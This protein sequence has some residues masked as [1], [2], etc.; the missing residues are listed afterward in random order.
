[1][2]SSP[3]GRAI[4]RHYDHGA[5]GP[6]SGGALNQPVVRAEADTLPAGTVTFLLT[7]IE[8]STRNWE[9][10]PTSMRS[11]LLRHDALLSTGIAEHAGKVLTERGEGDSFFAV[12][13]R[14]S[15]AAAAASSLQ[16]ALNA[17]VWPAEI[18]M[19]VRMAIH[20]GEAGGDYR[21]QDVNRCA[22]LRA[23]AHG[24]Q[25]LV[26]STTEALIRRNLPPGASLHDLRFHRL[27]DL[28]APEQV[29]QLDHAD[30]LSEFPRLR[31]LDSFKHNLPLQLTSFVGREAEID[32]ITRR[33]VSDRLLTIM[34]TGGSGKTR[35]AVQAAAELIEQF[36]DGVWFVD[37]SELA[38][39]AQIERA[40]ALAL[41][42]KEVPGQ[43]L[44]QAIVE[45]LEDAHVLLVLDNCEH[46][47]D[48]AAQLVLRLLR[49]GSAVRILATSRESLNV[50]GEATRVIPSLSIPADDTGTPVTELERYESV[51][52]F[53]DRVLAVQPRF[54]LNEGNAATVV[55]ICRRLDGVPLAI[56]LG[57]ARA[58]TMGLEEI[59][60]RLADRFR[61]LTGGSRTALPRQQ[62]LRAA[63]D[64]SHDLLSDPEK[65]LF[66]RLAVFAGGFDL[67]AAESVCEGGTLPVEDILDLLSA[68]VA[69]SLVVAETQVDGIGRY[70]LHE[71]LR[72][73][74]LERLVTCAEEA[75]MRDR[76]LAF[77]VEL[78][79]RAY[80]GA[81]RL[82]PTPPW[83]ERQEREQDN[84]RAALTWSRQHNNDVF[85]QLAGALSW[86]WWLRAV[87]IS[88]GREWLG[89]AIAT[90]PAPSPVMARAL[91]GAS[92]LASWQGDPTGKTTAKQGLTLWR[93]AGDQQGIGAGLEALGWSLVMS[94]DD[95]TALR[96]MEECLEIARLNG[97]DRTVN[98]AQLSVCQCLVNLGRVDEVQVLASQA[99]ARGRL[100]NEP[101]D[102]HFALHFLADSALARGAVLEAE[103]LYRQ[104][105]RATLAYGNKLQAGMEIQGMAMAFAGQGKP[106]KALRLNAAAQAWLHSGGMHSELVPFWAGYLRRYIDP[107]RET[108]DETALTSMEEA[109]RQMG[110]EAAID[111]ALEA[112]GD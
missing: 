35:L 89:D 93:Q 103:E 13:G 85:V 110:F 38:D 62:T 64:W 90:N 12:F 40:V 72:Q 82:E 71:T 34:G 17:E 109:G 27:R 41:E 14:A 111:S 19:R 22:R 86:L 1:V 88:E 10:S 9:A 104:S 96:H 105:L 67:E 63:V 5:S 29:F 32:E 16:L 65:T 31:S 70:R 33:L 49:S 15:D 58:K 100:L 79:E 107:L 7:D 56:E 20:T 47:V 45:K 11:A 8:G 21:G 23:I 52:L 42:I 44:G 83:L 91:T 106:G 78:A 99:L 18:A 25:I 48:A 60:V 39:A 77:F 84:F 37:L 43:A 97:S 6:V 98:R 73:Y 50:P 55:R 4:A 68:L 112:G 30:L 57:A 81:G 46:V 75:E 61:L 59:L 108:V 51:R 76:H 95:A 26:S 66:R 24:G 94:G 2:G 36:P 92:L 87:H 53:V 28:E 102:I 3:A 80:A 101:R 74:A 69:K 54:A